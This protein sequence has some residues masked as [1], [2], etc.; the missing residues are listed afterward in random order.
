MKKTV[1]LIL[2]LILSLSLSLLAGC[3][4]TPAEPTDASSG[5][6]AQT[7]PQPSTQEATQPACDHE[8]VEVPAALPT[9]LADGNKRYWKCKLC[10][11]LFGDFIGNS[12]VEWEDVVIP[13]EGIESYEYHMYNGESFD[14]QKL[15]T[16]ANDH[17]CQGTAIYEDTLFICNKYGYCYMYQLPKAEA[18]A[19]FPLAS[20]DDTDSP[21]Q[22]HSNQMMFGAEKFDE[23]DPYPL[24]YV[25]TGYSND[26][27]ET[28]AYYAKC[29][30]ERIRYDAAKGWY[31]ERVQLIEFNDAANIP[32]EDINGTLTEMYV[33]GKFPY[34]SGNGY[35]ASAGYEKIGYGW[36]HFYVDSAPTK[37][38]EGK[39]FTWSARWRGSEAWENKNLEKYDFTDY[40]TDNN[41]IITTFDMPALPA[42]ESDP[43]Y[44]GT[45]TLYPKDIVSQ[46]QTE[47]DIFAFQGG[48]MYNGK[49]YHSFGDARQDE[50]HRNGIRVFDIAQEKIVGRIALYDTDMADWEPECVCIY[51]GD[52]ALSTYNMND[53]SKAID[54]YIFGYVRDETDTDGLTCLVCGETLTQSK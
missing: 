21:T 28:G 52:L 46:F 6:S 18:I 36:P 54:M 8:L 35:D 31:A 29:S 14:L 45:V 37:A 53:D 2:A 38:T 39:I 10:G 17:A 50:K 30:V 40:V 15:V 26:H 43:A 44:G 22:N 23:S 49:L 47:F 25:T 33:D 20:F 24:L 4:Q 12:T 32:D 5:V 1:S 19:D 13:A 48:T 3:A 16:I 27:D 9:L 51:N 11:G 7:S 41:Y 42:S 34:V